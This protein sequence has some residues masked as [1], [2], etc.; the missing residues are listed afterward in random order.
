MSQSGRAAARAEVVAVARVHR[1]HG[2]RLL[3]VA[4][5][6]P[7]VLL[8]LA[9]TI[10][11]LLYSLRLSFF[12]WELSSAVANQEFV[13]L[14]NYQKVLFGDGRF[15]NAMLN[16]A[17]VVVLGV[18]IELALGTALALLVD[19]LGRA[20]SWVVAVLMIPVIIAPVVAG[21]EWRLVYNDQVGPLN[22]LLRQVGIP[23]FAWLADPSVAL[24]AI[25]IADI[26]QWTPFMMVLMLAGFQAVPSELYEAARV[27]GASVWQGFWRIT[28]PIL[29][30]IILVAVLVRGMDAF[31]LF[32]I[33]FLLTGGGPG[34]TTET[35]SFYTYL[36]GFRFFSMGYG[37]ALS[38]IQLII[39]TIVA[40]FLLGLVRR[41][42]RVGA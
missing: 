27:D 40:K 9:V 33:V 20:R 12:S 34:S 21:F 16:T 15:W 18:A 6:L 1:R 39:I 3:P 37:A 41:G 5:V 17:K 10:F 11:P 22:Y 31:K 4:F 2:L 38:Y 8:L 36:E 14:A 29:L 32:D 42:T 28:V 24:V 26:W 30:P 23:T 19:G 7:S 25:I 13:G 35:V